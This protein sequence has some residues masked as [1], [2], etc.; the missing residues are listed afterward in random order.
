[1]MR[2]LHTLRYG[3]DNHTLPYGYDNN[4]L[5]AA[6]VVEAAEQQ[7]NLQ[8]QSWQ[9]DDD[10]D[11][12]DDEGS[13]F[14]GKWPVLPTAFAIENKFIPEPRFHLD[15]LYSPCH[16][17]IN[18]DTIWDTD[19]HHVASWSRPPVYKSRNTPDDNFAQLFRACREAIVQAPQAPQ[20][21]Q[22]A[23]QA[24]LEPRVPQAVPT[25]TRQTLVMPPPEQGK[26]NTKTEPKSGTS[27]E[28]EEIWPPPGLSWLEVP[29]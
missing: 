8:I 5:A 21:L 13:W 20:D 26:P 15:P 12:S 27:D 17:P 9:E 11:D 28:K 10:D 6:T 1:M 16:D 2:L 22:E 23:H 25:T 14:T 3:Y 7:K 18:L 4:T 19:I 29:D 24:S